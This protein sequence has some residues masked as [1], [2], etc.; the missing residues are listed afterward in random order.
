MVYPRK[1]EF[2]TMSSFTRHLPRSSE[3]KKSVGVRATKKFVSGPA[4]KKV[5][6][7]ECVNPLTLHPI[8]PESPPPS[9]KTARSFVR[10]PVVP[11]RT[12]TSRKS[13]VPGKGATP[14]TSPTPTP[15][16]PTPTPV[17]IGKKIKLETE[18]CDILF[19]DEQIKK[20][21]SDRFQSLP[22]LQENLKSL[23]WIAED[24]TDHTD[25]IA[26]K[27]QLDVLRKTIQDIEG[28]FDMALYIFRSAG[29][30]EEYVKLESKTRS[31]GFV[32]TTTGRDINDLT[33]KAE[34]ISA[35]VRIAKEYVDLTSFS[36]SGV[37]GR[38]GKKVGKSRASCDWC[39]S[40]NLTPT[41]DSS[42]LI[43]EC[44][45][46]IELLDESI[47]FK[48][49]ERVNVSSR[50]T[51]SCRGHFV[52]AIN[53]FQA[54]QNTEI[55]NEVLE[56]LKKEMVLNDLTAKT[57][58]K[59]DL[60]T[61]LSDNKLGDSYADINLIH[62]LITDI[63]APDITNYC[64]ELLEMF[65]QLEDS[66]REVKDIERLNS[67]NVNWKLYKLLQLLDFPCKKGDFYCLKTPTKQDEHE[68]KWTSMI[69]YL[70]S[71]Y[72]NAKTSNG[73]DRWRHMRTI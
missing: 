14:E 67:L 26:A 56:T 12:S 43:C 28:C 5:A 15:P 44:G 13:T 20:L 31:S 29:L 47:S 10:A 48:D 46:L 50:Y 59:D 42:I 19:I 16:V 37:G 65:D 34:I 73:K 36:G 53:R 68:E 64:L 11:T 57:V 54:K 35:Y 18:G 9:P 21:L 39:H 72:P 17:V 45:K 41:D 27:A 61:F 23:R 2:G 40:L 24:S 4:T 38:N 71:R 58:Q 66:Y 62:L 63:P 22:S 70:R 69:T 1:E 52:E 55:P 60:Y 51:Y 33:R 3:T 25:R 32:R 30:L 8:S 7:T 49:S 6:S